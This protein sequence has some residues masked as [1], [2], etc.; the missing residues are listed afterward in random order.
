MDREK[1]A[2]SCVGEEEIEKNIEDIP[3]RNIKYGYG[4]E[5]IPCREASKKKYRE[6]L[7]KF[8]LIYIIL[9]KNHQNK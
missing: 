8:L 4:R 6:S 3:G 7:G 1:K 5:T 9:D 2:R